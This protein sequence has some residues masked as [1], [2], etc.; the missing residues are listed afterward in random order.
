MSATLPFELDPAALE[1][2]VAFITGASR[3]LGAGL[4]ARF[5][6][7]GVQLGLCARHEPDQPAGSD[8][9]TAAVDVTNIAHLERFADVVAETLGPIDLWINNAGVLDPMGPLRELAPDRITKALAVNVGGVITGTQIFID[10]SADAPE[11]RRAL[12]NISSGA[13]SSV[14]EGWSIYGAAKAAVDQLT[15]V[16]A[17]EEPTLVC[18]AVAPGVVDTDMQAFIR[19][20]DAE[21][22]PSIDR[23]NDIAARG[24]WNSPGWVADHLLGILSGALEPGDVVYRVPDEPR[25]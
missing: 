16:V 3:G 10:R 2:K 19:E 13:A 9:I 8:A 24:A 21:T 7:H 5:A 15:R 14:Y 6:E 23:F 4:A 1:G 20:Q 18:H 17:A 11:A 22:F 25:A 12:I